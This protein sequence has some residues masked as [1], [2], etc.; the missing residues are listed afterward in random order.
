MKVNKRT[1]IN[2]EQTDKLIKYFDE[3]AVSK[4][5]ERQV[6][7]T[8]HS[9]ADFRLIKTNDYITLDLKSN[10]DEDVVFI[11]KKYEKS[12]INILTHI[13]SYV[14]VKRFRTRHMYRYDNMYITIDE[15]LK[16]GNVLRISFNY[17]EEIEKNK[18]LN[19]IEEIY[20]KFDIEVNSM[21]TFLEL[22]SKYRTSWADLTKDIDEE[23]FLKEGC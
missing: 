16:Y 21:E 11:H 3:M 7:Y 20:Q 15:N 18:M 4:K 19:E 12:M 17:Q 23:T 8:Y 9:E 14:A 1:Y 6:I 13:G 10:N 2:K 5:E 22:Y